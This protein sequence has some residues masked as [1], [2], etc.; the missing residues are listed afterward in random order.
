MS[1]G[2]SWRRRTKSRPAEARGL[3]GCRPAGAVGGGPRC[4]PAG[5][6][7]GRP[8]AG[9]PELEVFEDVG[10]SELAAED[11]DVAWPELT[12]LSCIAC[13]KFISKEVEML[14]GKEVGADKKEK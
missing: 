5:A 3:Q 2:R 8:N 14:T 6:G 12:A 11:L 4:R 9:R 1:A 13:G 7:G 10:R